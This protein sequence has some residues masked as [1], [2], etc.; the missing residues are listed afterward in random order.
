MLI[1][2][3]IIFK[4]NWFLKIYILNLKISKNLNFL[5]KLIYKIK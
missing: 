3:F 5:L 1:R 4:N 2:L